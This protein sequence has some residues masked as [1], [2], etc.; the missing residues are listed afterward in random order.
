[1]GKKGKTSEQVAEE[2][3]QK[4]LAFHQS[5]AVLDRQLTDQLILPLALS[6]WSGLLLAEKLS[7]HTLTNLW[8]I[9]QFLGPVA[10]VNP[11]NNSI[12]FFQRAS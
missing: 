7:S 6:G 12:E 11:Q 2:A 1:M 10:Q 8:V 9:E 4:F 3:V 5:E